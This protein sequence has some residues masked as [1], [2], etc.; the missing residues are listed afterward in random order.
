MKNAGKLN[1]K[2]ATVEEKLK[3]VAKDNGLNF[4]KELKQVKKDREKMNDSD[5]SR[6]NPVDVPFTI[7]LKE[8]Y[9]MH[10]L[11]SWRRLNSMVGSVAPCYARKPW[12]STT[13]HISVI[14]IP[15]Y[16]NYIYNLDLMLD[17]HIEDRFCVKGKGRK[18][19]KRCLKKLV[20][21]WGDLEIVIYDQGQAKKALGAK[22][23]KKQERKQT[24]KQD[25]KK[26][27]KKRKKTPKSK[28]KKK[29]KKTQKANIGSSYKDYIKQTGDA[30]L[31]DIDDLEIKKNVSKDKMKRA[32]KNLIKAGK[33]EIPKRDPIDVK[34]VAPDHYG[35]IDGNA[36]AKLAKGFGWEKIPV[37]VEKSEKSSPE[38][39][40]KY[41][42]GD[43]LYLT[44]DWGVY[45]K[46]T[47]V[48]VRHDFYPDYDDKVIVRCCPDK[49]VQE[50]FQVPDRIL[51]KTKPK[52]KKPSTSGTTSESSDIDLAA[53][54]QSQNKI[55]EFIDSLI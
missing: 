39:K 9:D 47:Q 45:E 52:E 6:E 19:F 32:K 49:M 18:P 8:L 48:E 33:G 4:S 35:V 11:R 2:A 24:K 22:R 55:D 41:E 1:G 7:T 44:H 3:A 29:S 16:H 14:Y 26:S 28:K 50:A 27:K 34:K 5:E 36:T 43:L 17:G 25:K 21:K 54:Q 23:Y 37:I 38:K 20:D 40:P 51:S 12:E 53:V 13:A 10:K 30:K 15:D 42:S 46:G 31:L